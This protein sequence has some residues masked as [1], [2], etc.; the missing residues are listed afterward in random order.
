MKAHDLGA[1][2]LRWPTLQ[3]HAP[4]QQ[5]LSVRREFRRCSPATLLRSKKTDRIMGV[6]LVPGALFAPKIGRQR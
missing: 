2:I 1:N 5:K 4:R 6:A 3:R